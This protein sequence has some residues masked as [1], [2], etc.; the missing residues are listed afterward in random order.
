[1]LL[2]PRSSVLLISPLSFQPQRNK[3]LY[4]ST[5]HKN[6]INLKTVSDIEPLT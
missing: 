2:E 1:M 3:I 4:L 6:M 5:Y